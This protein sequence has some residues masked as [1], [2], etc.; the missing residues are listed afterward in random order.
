MDGTRHHSGCRTLPNPGVINNE[1]TIMARKANNAVQAYIFNADDA[2]TIGRNVAT[3][4]TQQKAQAGNN[5]DVLR[6]HYVAA[7][8]AG[9]A[10]E[11]LEATF[12][13]GGD[14][15]KGAKAAWYRAYKSNLTGAHEYGVTV[16][17]G[18]GATAVQ[19]AVRDAR[20]EGKSEAERQE[21]LYQMF[22]KMAQGALNAGVTKAKLAAGLKGLAA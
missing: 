16:T 19:N 20:Q 21:Q 2:T 22:L 8:D 6:T 13:N 3:I 5:W 15:V 7:Q 17:D 9:K 12:T 4:A 14:R 11:W 10:A 1:D 18:M